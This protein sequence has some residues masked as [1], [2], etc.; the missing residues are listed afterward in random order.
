[1]PRNPLVQG[2]RAALA[3]V[4][5][6]MSLVPGAADAGTG[7]PLVRLAQQS[8]DATPDETPP[9]AAPSEETAPPSK[10]ADDTADNGDEPFLGDARPAGPDLTVD[11]ERELISR[12]WD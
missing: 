11:Q 2:P 5:C 1:M 8:G 10:A 6:A 9:A 12:G 7:S 4:V 3:A